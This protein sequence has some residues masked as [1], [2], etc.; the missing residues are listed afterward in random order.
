[1]GNNYDPV[2]GYYDFLSRLVFGRSE[3]NAQVEFLPYIRSASSILIV[4]GGTGWILEKLAALHSSGLRITYVESSD[5]M[6]AFSKKRYWGNN[7]VRF[8]S[9]PVERFVTEE[10]YDVILTGFFFDN[11]PGDQAAKIFELLDVLLKNGGYWLF[12][13]FY[14]RKGEGMFWQVLLLRSMYLSAGILCAVEGRDLV[15]MEP[16]FAATGYKAVS[17]SFHYRRFIKSIIYQKKPAE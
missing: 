11:F 16:L 13:D 4:G 14:Y 10:Q 3:I 15:N 1:M 2:A 17:A 12:A 5:R 9:L 6:M 7:E 8:V